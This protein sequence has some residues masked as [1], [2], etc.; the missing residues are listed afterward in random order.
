MNMPK[1]VKEDL[2]ATAQ[3]GQAP[4]SEETSSEAVTLNP[5]ASQLA[6][7]HQKHQREVEL[8]R[9]KQSEW[10]KQKDSYVPKSDL[11]AKF[12]ADPVGTLQE[13]GMTYDQFNERLLAKLNG[14]DPV[15]A[16]ESR[17]D[18]LQKSQEEN[19][20]KQYEATL[21]QYKTEATALVAKDLKAYHFISKGKHED[22]VVQHI[23]DTWEE[24]PDQ[25]LTVEQAAKEIEEFLRAEAKEKSDLLRE[26]DPPQEETVPQKKQLPPPQRSAAPRTLTNDTAV[27]PQRTYGQFQHLS[28]KERIAQ[29]VARASK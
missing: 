22:A 14:D 2:Q 25:V 28:M 12:E 9:Q 23:V 29:A 10:E 24:N 11:R 16:L 5:Q 21:K 18:N 13:F 6:R 1:L 19:V 7:L 4:T 17:I 27:S 20:N 15:K 8:L 3:T 26:L